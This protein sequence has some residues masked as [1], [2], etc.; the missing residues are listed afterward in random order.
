VLILVSAARVLRAAVHIL[1]EG[2]P[3]GVNANEGSAGH[4]W[5]RP[6]CRAYTICTSGR[7][8]SG[9]VALSAHVVMCDDTVAQAQSV[10]QHVRRL[11]AE[12]FASSIPRSSSSGMIAASA[13]SACLA[14]VAEWAQRHMTCASGY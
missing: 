13:H 7:S 14:R 3:E 4:R 9:Y 10:Q 5:P 11:L 2:T 6:E 1:N 12:R 8:A